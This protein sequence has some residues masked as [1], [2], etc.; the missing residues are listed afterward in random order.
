MTCCWLFCTS[1]PTE[2]GSSLKRKILLSKGANSIHLELTAFRKE[3]K[4]NMFVR[5]VSF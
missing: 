1:S 4:K 2:N 3:Q 5:Y